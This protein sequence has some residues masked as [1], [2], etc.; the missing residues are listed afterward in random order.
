M[1]NKI[2]LLFSASNTD[3][4]DKINNFLVSEWELIKQKLPDVQH[5]RAI[6][7]PNDPTASVPQDGQPD[8]LLEQPPFDVMLELRGEDV[9]FDLLIKAI[10]GIGERLGPLIDATNSAALL[11][12]EHMIVP[13]N[14]PLF[15][16]MVLRRP[17]KWS[18][19]DWH[20]HWLE[21]HAADVR[22]NVSGLQ[23]YRQF[24][25]DEQASKEAAESAR[26]G[27]YDYEGTAEGYYS[28]IEK[29]LETLSDPEVAKDTG[30]IDHSRSV[31]WL[32]NL[33]E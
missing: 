20:D 11:G 12:N 13:G 10:E 17:S 4:R 9:S 8:D 2:Q 1:I 22:E 5:R 23:G 19:E 29:F 15:L 6:R 30:F 18:R 16:N 24:H 33:Y 27:I 21:H 7:V 26:V 28:D 3:D 14:E 32:Y 31:M 25:A